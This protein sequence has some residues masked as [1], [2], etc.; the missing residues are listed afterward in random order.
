M[1]TH[2]DI[3]NE[4]ITRIVQG[5]KVYNVPLDLQIDVLRAIMYKDYHNA[6]T[7]PAVQAWISEHKTLVVERFKAIGA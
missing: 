3:Q 2:N 1:K 5:F 7:N 6:A 4:T